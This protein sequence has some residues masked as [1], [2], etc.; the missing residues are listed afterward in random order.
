[1][2]AGGTIQAGPFVDP[3][4]LATI[5]IPAT[6]TQAYWVGICDDPNIMVEMQEDSIGNNLAVTDIGSNLDLVSGT[7]NGFVSGWMLDSS[8]VNTG[9]TRQ[10]RLYSLIQRNDNALGQYA[11]W[12]A[13]PNNHELKIGTTGV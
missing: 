1:M 3:A 11:K 4:N 2:T 13:I 12:L 7:N 9:S 8:T 10:M 5:I 6:K